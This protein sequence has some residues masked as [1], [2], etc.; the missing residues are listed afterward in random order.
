MANYTLSYSPFSDGWTSFHS[1][2]PE[3][4]VHM[5]N[6]FYTFNRGRLYKHY[7]NDIR[8]NYYGKNH[9]ATIT[10]VLNDSPLEAKMFKTIELNSNRPWL[11]EITTNLSSGKIEDVDYALKEGDYYAYIRRLSTDTNLSLMSAQGI[12]EV[13]SVSGTSPGSITLDFNFDLGSIVSIGDSLYRDNSGIELIGVISGLTSTSI[14]LATTSITPVAG[15]FILY[16]KNAQAESY[17]SRGYYAELKL[18]YKQT[19][20]VEL[21]SLSS[22]IFKSFP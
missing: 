11:T 9:N 16:L 8:G 18:T 22:E 3:S 15:N 5:N 13:T 10:T 21:F 2:T 1:F 20:E 19:D 17:G 6:H 7:D 4:M 14:T 12:G